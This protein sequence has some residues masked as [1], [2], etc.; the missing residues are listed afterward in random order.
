[1]WLCSCLWSSKSRLLL[2]TRRRIGCRD[3]QA[4]PASVCI[5]VHTRVRR[6][7][8]WRTRRTFTSAKQSVL[9]LS[10]AH[11]LHGCLLLQSSPPPPHPPLLRAAP[12]PLPTNPCSTHLGFKI[13]TSTHQKHMV[14]ITITIAGILKLILLI[15]IFL[16]LLILLIL[17]IRI[18]IVIRSSLSPLSS[19]SST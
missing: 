9:F 16:I 1:M 12:F 5:R 10:S 7:P 19:A 18:L 15:P 2:G 17:P 14:R 11:S 6:Q 3:W 4:A 8:A 13:C